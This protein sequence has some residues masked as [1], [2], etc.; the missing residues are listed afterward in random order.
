MCASFVLF[1][2]RDFFRRKKVKEMD[3]ITY[4]KITNVDPFYSTVWDS[5]TNTNSEVKN[6][7]CK[8]EYVVNGV[9]YSGN[10]VF[11]FRKR[12]GQKIKIYYNEMKPEK[13]ETAE[14]HNH[15]LNMCIFVMLIFIIPILIAYIYKK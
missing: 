1:F 13:N 11:S 8:Y 12:V 15:S 5:E 4:A 7:R 14:E 9:S 10:H 3:S 2:F 6:Y